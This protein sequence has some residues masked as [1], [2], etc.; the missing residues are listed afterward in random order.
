M[1]NVIVTKTYRVKLTA[2]Q[3][4]LY[5]LAGRDHA[6]AD[7][8][9]T[10]ESALNT[11]S[12]RTGAYGIMYQALQRNAAFGAA[13]TEGDAMVM[14]LLDLRFSEETCNA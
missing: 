2:D 5:D 6:A 10:C 7:L 4:Q 12:T 1:R 11:C 9:R 14:R 3:W 13:D 8:N